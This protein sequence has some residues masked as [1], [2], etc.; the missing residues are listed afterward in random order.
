MKLY[1]VYGPSGKLL[2]VCESSWEAKVSIFDFQSREFREKY[3]HKAEPAYRAAKKL[4]WKIEAG[5]YKGSGS[6]LK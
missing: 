4:G 5:E 2:D 6:F 3:W 1:G